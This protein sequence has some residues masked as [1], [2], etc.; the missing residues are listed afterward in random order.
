MFR[1][2]GTQTIKTERL[3]L[4]KFKCDDAIEV[5]NNWASNPNIQLD[6]GEP[7]YSSMEQVQEFLN[8]WIL[9]YEDD[10]FYKW[11]I[12]LKEN[13][14]NIGQIA[15][16]RVYEEVATAEIE[17]CIGEHYWGNRYAL[18]ALNAVIEFMFFNSDFNK[19]EAYH[20]KD[21]P[22]S[23]RVL[24]KTIMK[25]VPTVRRFELSAENTDSEI[26][27]AI[28]KKEFIKNEK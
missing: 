11:A 7:V 8:K 1:H 24:E 2:I 17:Y 27:Y 21:N 20:R 6:Y 12:N 22:K 23:G 16:C 14:V 4:R 9:N 25:R 13:H 10:G 28:T 26:C 15:F 18:E 19:L 5:Y 3:I